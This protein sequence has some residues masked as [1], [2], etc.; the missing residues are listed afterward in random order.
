MKTI[1]NIIKRYWID[2]KTNIFKN[3]KDALFGLLVLVIIPAIS[4]C[5]GIYSQ[6]ITF[7][8]YTFPILS[9]SIASL[10]DTYGRYEGDSP[11][12]IKLAIRAIIN[13]FALLFSCVCLGVN[14]IVLPYIAPVLLLFSGLLLV[15]E[16][17]KRVK[18]AILL[19]P[20]NC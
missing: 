20:W 13:F 5:L 1:I 11:K 4:I 2:E 12:N 14:S 7:W 15:F 8:S 19:S 6:P 18:Y 16:I 3:Y 10:Y 9:I 17:W